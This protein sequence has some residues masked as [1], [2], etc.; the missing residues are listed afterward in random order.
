MYCNWVPVKDHESGKLVGE[1]TKML[2]SHTRMHTHIST[3][4]SRPDYYFNVHN[5]PV[6]CVSRSPFF[7][8]IVLTV[9]GWTFAIWKEGAQVRQIENLISDHF[10]V[11]KVVWL[12]L[13]FGCCCCVLVCLSIWFF[14]FVYVCLFVT[15]RCIVEVLQFYNTTHWRG[16]VTH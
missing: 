11:F 15:E 10:F 3:P 6:S 1:L 13:L 9:G 7:R 2:S 8:D 12:Y 14:V 16:V 5:G 4:A